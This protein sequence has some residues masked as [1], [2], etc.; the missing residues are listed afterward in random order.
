MLGNFDSAKLLLT[1][2]FYFD[3]YLD[4]AFIGF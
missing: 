4:L 2:A 1:F 3:F